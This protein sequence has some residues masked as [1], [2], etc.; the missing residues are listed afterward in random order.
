MPSLEQALKA[1]AFRFERLTA[2]TRNE[3]ALKIASGDAA[4]G[5]IRRLGPNDLPAPPGSASR[6]SRVARQRVSSDCFDF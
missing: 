4:Q 3:R 6:N 5:P 1:A 2:T